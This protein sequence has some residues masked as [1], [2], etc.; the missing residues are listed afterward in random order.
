MFRLRAGSRVTARMSGAVSCYESESSP[1]SPG[2][3]PG[4]AAAAQRL[5]ARDRNDFQGM[6]HASLSGPACAWA[7]AHSRWG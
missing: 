5:P 2:P 7:P 3:Q 1:R 6:M 4:P